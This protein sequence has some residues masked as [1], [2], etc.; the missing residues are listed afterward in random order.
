MDEKYN[1]IIAQ[2]RAAGKDDNFIYNVLVNDYRINMNPNTARAVLGM[3]SEENKK[4]EDSTFVFAQDPTNPSS[5]ISSSGESKEPSPT[6]PEPSLQADGESQLFMSLED[7][8]YDPE[9]DEQSFMYNAMDFFGDMRRAASEGFETGQMTTETT[10]AGFGGELSDTN[11]DQ[12]V[13][14]LSDRQSGIGMSDEARALNE[15]MKDMSSWEKMKLFSSN[16]A[17]VE[18]IVNSFAQQ[19]GAIF[20]LERSAIASG[21]AGAAVSAAA[22]AATGGGIGAVAGAGVGAAP[23]AAVGGI[24]GFFPGFM[25]GVGASVEA[26]NVIT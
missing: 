13:G 10:V 11:M 26:N 25:G 16:Q 8:F 7:M 3:A 5:V 20:G 15:K 24:L 22:G 2:F 23:G 12:L 19:A 14:M 1:D 9:A 6:E 18:T 4:K 17:A 21:L